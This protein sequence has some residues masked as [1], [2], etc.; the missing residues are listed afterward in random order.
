[1]ARDEVAA[2]ETWKGQNEPSFGARNEKGKGNA[3]GKK[4]RGKGAQWEARVAEWD[5][6]KDKPEDK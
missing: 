5:K 3:K 1:M 2:K 6:N 4:G